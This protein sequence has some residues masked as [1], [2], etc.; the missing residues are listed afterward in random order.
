MTLTLFL[1]SN[2]PAFWSWSE[3][4]QRPEW[5][6]AVNVDMMMNMEVMLWAWLNGGETK[7]ESA[8][9]E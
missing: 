7:Y 3:P 4:S 6:R 9:E 8:V 5:E 2:I 1:Q